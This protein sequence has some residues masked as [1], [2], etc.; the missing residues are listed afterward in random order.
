VEHGRVQDRTGYG[1]SLTSEASLFI[2]IDSHPQR[3]TNMTCDADLAKEGSEVLELRDRPPSGILPGLGFEKWKNM[4][5]C[6]H[7]FVQR[8]PT[9]GGA[10]MQLAS[11]DAAHGWWRAAAARYAHAA[12]VDA[13]AAAIIE[14]QNRLRE[15]LALEQQHAQRPNCT[16]NS[17]AHCSGPPGEATCKRRG[18]SHD[19]GIADVVSEGDADMFLSIIMVT[20]HDNTQYCQAP[21]DACVDRFRASMSA[22][23]SLL[24]THSLASSTEVVPPHPCSHDPHWPH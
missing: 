14:Q 3:L 2:V 15:V 11:L 13:V 19:A 6:L 12:Q 5:A 7:G 8:H 20:R 1:Q 9:S 23:F 17:Y 22:L 18:D 24:H 21:A 4:R 16:W 10:Q